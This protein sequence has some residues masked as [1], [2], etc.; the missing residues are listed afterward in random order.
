MENGRIKIALDAGRQPSVNDPIYLAIWCEAADGYTIDSPGGI[1][2][3]LTRYLPGNVDN[4]KR[5]EM[6]WCHE[7]VINE[8]CCHAIAVANALRL[9][10]HELRAA[11]MAVDAPPSV[12]EEGND[13]IT[14][15][16]PTSTIIEPPSWIRA[17]A[18]SI[19]SLLQRPSSAAV[20]AQQTFND[21]SGASSSQSASDIPAP[22]TFSPLT[23]SRRRLAIIDIFCPS[24]DDLK[25]VQGFRKRPDGAQE[26]DL[27]SRIDAVIVDESHDLGNV[28]GVDTKLRIRC[29]SRLDRYYNR[30]YN[31]VLSEHRPI[32]QL[33]VEAMR[34]GKMTYTIDGVECPIPGGTSEASAIRSVFEDLRQ[35]FA[36]EAA[37]SAEAFRLWG[38]ADVYTPPRRPDVRVERRFLEIHNGWL[39]YHPQDEDGGEEND[40]QHEDEDETENSD[41]EFEPEP[42][43]ESTDHEGDGSRVIE[44]D[45]DDDSMEVEYTSYWEPETDSDS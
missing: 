42:E 10:N 22:A 24:L 17:I 3:A 38:L 45:S 30:P 1:G 6:A 39:M 35:D 23:T 7:P 32:E 26:V 20:S 29:L 16:P 36:A 11:I 19:K 41:T 37:F 8:S 34:S 5:V 44:L 13:D 14:P 40:P 28:P 31:L 27:L 33:A 9:A 2:I 25:R 43:S 18:D 4:R 15:V 12:G 21:T